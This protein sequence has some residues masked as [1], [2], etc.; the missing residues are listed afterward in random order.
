MGEGSGV[1]FQENR[2]LDEIYNRDANEPRCPQNV[3]TCYLLTEKG[4]EKY[5]YGE[6]NKE[7]AY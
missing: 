1:N 5:L 4:K 7:A 3:P 6:I 2:G